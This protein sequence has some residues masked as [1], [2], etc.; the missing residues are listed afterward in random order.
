M[1]SPYTKR[2]KAPLQKKTKNARALDAIASNARVVHHYLEFL[3]HA[4]QLAKTSVNVAADFLTEFQRL[5][6]F[7]DY[8]KFTPQHIIAY[9]EA[10]STQVGKSGEP[11]SMASLVA[12]VRRVRSFVIW[13]SDQQGYRSRVGRTL[14]EYLTLSNHDLRIAAA[15]RSRPV[16]SIEQIRHVLQSMPK[17]C[18][19][20][21]RN[22]ALVAFTLL[23]AAR[24]DAVVSLQLR[25]IDLIARTVTQDARIV[26]TKFRKTFISEFFPVGE[27][28]E[29]IVN[30]WIRYLRREMRFGPNDPLFPAT[31]SIRNSETSLLGPSGLSRIA[32]QTPG[33]ARIVFRTAWANAGLPYYNP[34][35]FRSTIARFGERICRTPEEFKSWSQS[36]GHANISVTL[37]SYGQVPEYRQNEVFAQIRK[38]E[39]E[40]ARY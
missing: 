6:K 19:I 11:Y 3:K 31:N 26:R 12:R 10:L 2:S 14:S 37:Q 24:I 13:L 33:P 21:L 35:S 18:G 15:R 8:K 30:D 5:T 7:R 1:T 27:D 38:R 32:W 16:P 39:E 23:S 28:I 36:L 17:D 4:Q 20:A 29:Q 40:V 34:H 22:R 25:H 9:K